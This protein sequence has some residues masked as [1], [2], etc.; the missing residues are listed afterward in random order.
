MRRTE[1]T[2]HSH[3]KSTGSDSPVSSIEDPERY[4]KCT[5]TGNNIIARYGLERPS[6]VRFVFLAS[7]TQAAGLNEAYNFSL[8]E[9]DNTGDDDLIGGTMLSGGPVD[10]LS[11][12]NPFAIYWDEFESNLTGSASS[13]SPLRAEF[14]LTHREEASCDDEIA[15]ETQIALK[16]TALWDEWQMITNTVTT[17]GYGVSSTQWFEF[18]SFANATRFLSFFWTRW[19]HHCPIVHK[20]TFKLSDCSNIL[21]ATICMVGACMSLSKEDHDSGRRL[22]DVIEEIIFSR[23]MLKETVPPITTEGG[24][25]QRHQKVQT[26]QATCFICLLQKWEGNDIAKLRMQRHRFTAFVAVSIF[27]AQ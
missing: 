7:F 9:H 21:F 12:S 22:L 25:L 24:P 14:D 17:D 19:H 10:N 16:A 23:P 27:A 2:Y 26:L 6:D 20:A 8:N 13:I 5:T 4:K 3:Q 11:S 18:F 1:C 15:Q